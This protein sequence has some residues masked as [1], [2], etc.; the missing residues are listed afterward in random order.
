MMMAL[1]AAVFVV[2]AW[3]NSGFGE[4]LAVTAGSD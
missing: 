2:L 4:P 3:R 1:G